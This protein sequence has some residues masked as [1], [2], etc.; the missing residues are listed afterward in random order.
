[1]KHCTSL[2][3]SLLLAAA[4][5]PALAEPLPRERVPEPLRPWIDWA[6]RG[7]EAE[8][9]PAFLGNVDGDDESRCAWPGRLA[10]D[11]GEKDGKWSQ[12]WEV[13]VPGFVPLPGEAA[14]WPLDVQVDGKPAAAIP[15][16]GVLRV[17]ARPGTW[18]LELTARHAGPVAALTLPPPGGPWA[19]EEV[20][21]FD[22]RPGLR[23]ADVL[24]VPA[25]DPQQTSLPDDWKKLPAYRLRPGETLRIA[26]R[27]RGDAD[28]PPDQLTL[29]HTLWLDFDGD[30][31][32]WQDL[33]SGTL[34][35]S[36]RLEMAP[37]GRLE[38]VVIAGRDQVITQR[39]DTPRAGI[40]V[41]QG[42]VLLA[43]E[44]RLPGR[45]AL[46]AV[47]WDHDFQ[48]VSGELH[49]PP[50]WRLL[51]ATGVDQAPG[52]WVS[53]WTLLDLFL[54]LLIAL[55]VRHLWGTRWGALAL[56]GL[57]L[58]WQEAEA[59]QWIWIAVL[60]TAALL[61]LLPTG[62]LRAF[63]RLLAL[64]SRIGLALIA[65]AFLA[66]QLRPAIHPAPEYPYAAASRD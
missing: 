36:W 10:L 47:G 26:E 18:T 1:M 28:P 34:T 49:L 53:R 41:R 19:D 50:G 64:A 8:L 16:D 32:T 45:F 44:G 13:Q 14:R 37:P 55:A 61:P 38:R 30:G 9:C 58:T 63:V 2:L 39:D 29:R 6:L 21:V 40:E 48:A 42:Q 22:A 11:L 65:I 27:R 60:A 54:V 46:P 51:A 31:Y 3:L 52:A 20:W 43:A 24:G 23:L 15:Q 12:T 56:L 17:Q 66:Q 35:R 62:R 25:V 57:V 33:L 5:W 59:P 4:V 7:H